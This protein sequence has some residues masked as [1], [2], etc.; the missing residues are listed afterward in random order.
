ME[1][2]ITEVDFLVNLQTVKYHMLKP[3]LMIHHVTDDI[4]QH[5]L[6]EFLLTFDD[7]YDDHYTTFSKFLEIPTQ[8]IYFITCGWVGLPGFLTVEQIKYMNSF[9]DVTIGAHSFA[10]RDFANAKLTLPQLVDFLDE[11]TAK[12]RTWFEENLGFVP[13]TFCYPYNNSI[14]GMYTKILQRYRFTEFYGSERIDVSW[15][16]NPPIWVNPLAWIRTIG[17]DK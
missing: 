16:S 14:H 13:T 11:D 3:S 5:P 17:S 10:H 8:K 9:D 4:F 12:T 1:K 15:L 7:G 6:E 2:I